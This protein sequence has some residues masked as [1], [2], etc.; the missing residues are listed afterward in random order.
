MGYSNL[1]WTCPFF[2]KDLRRSV[3]CEAGR[4]IFGDTEHIQSYTHAYC[5]NDN[6]ERCTLAQQLL[7]HY[8]RIEAQQQAQAVRR[9]YESGGR[10]HTSYPEFSE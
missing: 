5:A 6:W 2:S 7:R 9:F 1:Y 3:T 10:S 4:L 8:D